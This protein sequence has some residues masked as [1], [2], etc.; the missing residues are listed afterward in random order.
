MDVVFLIPPATD[1]R[2]PQL[3]V[4]SLVA[5]LRANGVS[6]QVRDLNLEGLLS[7]LDPAALAEATRKCESRFGAASG[8]ERTRL[9]WILDHADQVVTG[10][11]TALSV[12]R[13]SEAFYDPHRH[14][15][16]RACVIAALDLVSAASGRVHYNISTALYEVAGIDSSRLADLERV[17]AE[18]TANLFY[19]LY[20]DSV[21]P[22]LD[23]SSPDLVGISILN[24]QQILPGLMLARLLKAHGHFIVIGGT[25]YAKFVEQ[26]MT[27]PRFLTLFCDALVPYEGETAL[28]ALLEQ[29]Q[30]RRDLASVPNLLH[31]GRDGQPVIGRTHVETVDSLPTPDFG[32]LPLD[33]YLSPAPVLPILTGK[34]CYFNR[35]KFCDIPFINAISTKAYRVRSPDLVA[36]D[37]AALQARHGARHFEITDETLSPK[38]LLQLADAL[39]QHPGVEARF[40]GYARM[41]PRFTAEVC[42]RIYEMGMRKLFFGLES[43]SQA[44]LKHMRKAI[45]LD[46]ARAVLRN[47]ARAGIGF[48][49][50]SIIGFPEEG[51]ASAR[52]TLEFM[53]DETDVLE[54]PRNS[55][56]IHPFGLDLRTEYYDHP[57]QYGIV[58]DAPALAERDFPISVEGWA[59]TRGLDRDDVDRLLSE[60]GDVLR[61]RFAGVRNYPDTLWPG[62]EEYAVLYSDYYDKRPF[63][64]RFSLPPSGDPLPLLLELADDVRVRRADNGRCT[65]S[66]LIGSVTIGAPALVVLAVRRPPAP[67]D[68]LLLALASEF[69]HAPSQRESLL[70]ELRAV[71]DRLLAIRAVWLV[72][73]DAQRLPTESAAGS[74]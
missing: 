47:C 36:S 16:A 69:D 32:C 20:H 21:L 33:Q 3:A 23:Q 31:L 70:N 54:H 68:D 15:H 60:F 48:H 19:D 28:L 66:T 58:I 2:S 13:D 12:L 10:I 5:H 24:G 52:Q 1:V 45:H 56:D 51:E 41:E 4:P 27:R 50:F 39:D 59:N 72:P 73:E 44:T 57:E 26:L 35:C 55:F 18:P 9:R 17:T 11:T 65:V 37:I 38:L 64:F 53:L 40:V 30:G 49:V 42:S 6:T 8:D 61:R 14:H 34:G 29:L 22:E 25:V 7:F 63:H 43:G 67:V 74:T 46:T 71:I 62:F